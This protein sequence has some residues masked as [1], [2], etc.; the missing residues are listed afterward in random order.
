MRKILICLVVLALVVGAFVFSC[1]DD[2]TSSSDSDT[3]DDDDHVGDDDNDTDDDDL[4]QD[5]DDDTDDDDGTDDDDDDEVFPPED[6]T[7]FMEKG[8]ILPPNSLECTPVETDVPQLNCNHHGSVVTQ[9]P[10]GSMAAVWY[11]GVAEKSLDS[12]ILWSKIEPEA[13]D[14]SWPEV[15]YDDPDLSEGNPALW[16]GEDDTFYLFF[17]SILGDGWNQAGIRLTESTDLGQSWS[18]PKMLRSQYCWMPRHR[19]V[20]L[21][22]GDLLLPLYNECLASPTFMR[23]TDNF[24]TWTEEGHL[25]L[26]YQLAHLGQIQPALAVFEDGT[27]TAVTRDGFPTNRVKRMVSTDQGQTWGPSVSTALPNAGTS[28]DQVR[29]L[30]GNVVVVYNDSPDKRFP[31][32]VAHSTDQGATYTAIRNINEECDSEPC[33]YSYPS[34]TQNTTDGTIWVTYTHERQTIGWVHFNEAWLLQGE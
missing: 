2:A 13:T 8:F 18:A 17:A 24:A 15:L 11:H 4:S 5:D 29:L 14:W 19:P 10:G 34:I 31:L 25:S 1:G 26:E 9:L 32:T 21:T 20:R 33:K 27:I 3:S 30:D 16:V 7:P 6:Q 23:S 22:N 28:I 12:R